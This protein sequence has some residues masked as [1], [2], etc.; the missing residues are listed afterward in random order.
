[1]E[2]KIYNT[3]LSEVQKIDLTNALLDA[4]PVDPHPLPPIGP[5]PKQSNT[6]PF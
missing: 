6:E 3:P 1:M 5:A 4:S 2:K